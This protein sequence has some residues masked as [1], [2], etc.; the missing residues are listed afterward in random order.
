MPGLDIMKINIIEHT[1][2]MNWGFIVVFSLYGP[3]GA[4][5][6]KSLCGY[7]QFLL[8][9]DHTIII[10]L[11]IVYMIYILEGNNWFVL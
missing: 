4:S 1:L 5:N 10:L 3:P 6:L 9:Y 8:G 2:C 7:S 11:I